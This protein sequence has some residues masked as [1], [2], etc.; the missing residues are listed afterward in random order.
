MSVN[1]KKS[2]VQQSILNPQMTKQEKLKYRIISVLS[3]LAFLVFW[4]VITDGL[5]VFK[6]SQLR[7]PINVITALIE[8]LY[9]KAPD[10]G[11]LFEHIGESLR[12]VGTG[13]VVGTVIGIPLGIAMA[14]NRTFDK[15]VGPVF[16]VIRYIPPIAWIPIMILIFGIGRT[17]KIA[18]IF[19]AAFF[20]NVLNAYEGIKQTKDVHIWTAQTFGATRHQLLYTVAIPTAL[21][22]ILT[23]IKGALAGSWGSVVAAELLASNRGIGYMIQNARTLGRPDLVLAGIVCIALINAL[24]NLIF[25]LIERVLIRGRLDW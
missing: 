8:K 17:S 16:N 5:H 11:T 13:F 21:P 3:L 15:I 10:N 12:I 24:L 1:S 25:D 2:S 14:W 23:G 18:V 6:P 20:G 4:W 7:S 19:F 9:T 22:Q